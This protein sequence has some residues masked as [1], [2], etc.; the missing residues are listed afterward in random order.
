MAHKKGASS[1]R[2]GRDSAAQRLGV[3]RFG[4]QVVNAGEILIRQRGTKFH[5][6]DLVGRGGDDT[7]FAL[8]RGRG[9]VRHQAWPQDR[10]HRAGI[11]AA[12]VFSR[13]RAGDLASRP[14]LP[15][16]SGYPAGRIGDVTTFVDRVVLHLQ[17][18]DGGHGCVSIHREK[19]KPLGGPDGGNG[20]HGGSVTL[21]VDP[22][23]AHAAR[24]PFP[25]ARQGRERQG[26][27]GLRPGRRQ[28]RATWC[29]RCPTARSCRPPTARCSPTWS[30]PA[31]RSRWPAA[32][33]AAAATPRWPTP[34]A[35]RPASPNSAS[36]ASTSTS[37]WSSRASPTSAWSASRRPASPR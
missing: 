4:G 34:A 12:V 13:Q 18:G 25:P 10:Q 21:V 1:S 26:R 11:G 33:A 3:K 6:G 24:L 27:R 2:N 16:L 7:L 29:C 22:Q 35:R 31:R 37:C 36:R 30:A 19:F 20:G 28:R 23:R 8:V 5:P 32:A 9:P 14:A 15:F 17:A